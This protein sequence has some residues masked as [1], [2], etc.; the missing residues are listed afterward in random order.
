MSANPSF[1]KACQ[2]KRYPAFGDYTL[3]C[4]VAGTNF[5]IELFETP[6]HPY[7]NCLRPLCYPQ[8][9][10][11]FICFSL[12][13]PE[14]YE[15]VRTKWYSE[16]RYHGPSSAKIVLVG[17][18]LDLRDD[19]EIVDDLTNQNLTPISYAEG[20]LLCRDIIGQKY[21]ECSAL[22]QQGVATLFKGA[23]HA[24]CECL[25]TLFTS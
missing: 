22:T 4:T 2:L 14:S 19:R 17:T 18:K 7:H 11:F 21:Y 23:V 16:V 10:V 13:D 20:E 12:T 25:C 24:A 3:R 5:T 6:G 9:D 8:T 1:L 15:S